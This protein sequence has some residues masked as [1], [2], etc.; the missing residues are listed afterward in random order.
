VP[1]LMSAFTPKA[2]IGPQLLHVRSG[3]KADM[4]AAKGHVCFTPESGHVRRKCHVCFGQI[5]DVATS[6]VLWIEWIIY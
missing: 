6:S 4:C 2:N 5:A 3:S 1:L